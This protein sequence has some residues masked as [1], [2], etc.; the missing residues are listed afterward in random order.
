MLME[1]VKGIKKMMDNKVQMC[2]EVLSFVSDRINGCKET[3]SKNKNRIIIGTV[4]LGAGVGIGGG[5]LVS[6]F[7][8]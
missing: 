4:I 7:I 2:K 3:L 1:I 8:Q 6:G 5:L